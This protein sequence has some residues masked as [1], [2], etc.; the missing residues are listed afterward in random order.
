M[1]WRYNQPN[2]GDAGRQDS[3]NLY[4]DSFTRLRGRALEVDLEVGL[5]HVGV[6]I[7][8]PLIFQRF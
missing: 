2:D 3:L 6:S 8:Q 5:R 7:L 1:K 4:F